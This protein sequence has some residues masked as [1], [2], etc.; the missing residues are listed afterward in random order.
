MFDS[1]KLGY[2]MKQIRT[3]SSCKCKLMLDKHLLQCT[4]KE[5]FKWKVK[6]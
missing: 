4:Q 3:F 1:N 5:I 2:V 6:S